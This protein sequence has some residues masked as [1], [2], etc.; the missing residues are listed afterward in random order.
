MMDGYQ[1]ATALREAAQL[2]ERAAQ[3]IASVE[4]EGFNTSGID[5][6]YRHGEL[7]RELRRVADIYANDTLP[8]TVAR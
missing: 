8:I 1:K 5:H 4:H 3:L 6:D 2:I 7:P